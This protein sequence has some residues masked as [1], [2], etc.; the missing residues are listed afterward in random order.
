V[1]PGPAST[2]SGS[3]TA[4]DPLDSA[5]IVEGILG[6]GEPAQPVAARDQ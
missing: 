5:A 3:G 4:G 1:P 6:R 2:H